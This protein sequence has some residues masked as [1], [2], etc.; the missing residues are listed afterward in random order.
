M[1]NINENIYDKIISNQEKRMTDLLELEKY[2]NTLLNLLEREWNENK[3]IHNWDYS[4]KCKKYLENAQILNNDLKSL[5]ENNQDLAEINI[6]NQLLSL[7]ESNYK[8]TVLLFMK[9]LSHFELLKK[10][11][12]EEEFESLEK[13]IS[14]L[15]HTQFEIREGI[16]D[17]VTNLKYSKI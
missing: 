17:I 8:N 3:K 2:F 5:K 1:Q 7:E 13:E 14:A 16:S 15:K 4:A 11:A 12:D 9:K 10:D 6:I